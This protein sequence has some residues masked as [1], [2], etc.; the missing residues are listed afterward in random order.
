MLGFDALGRLALGQ[1]D[2]ITETTMTTETGVLVVTGV[3]A[4]TISE[5]PEERRPLYLRGQ[6]YWK[7]RS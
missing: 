2:N 1:L 7:G 4:D 5:P 3:D 6:S